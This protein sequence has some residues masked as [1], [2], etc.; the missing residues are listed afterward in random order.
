VCLPCSNSPSI[1]L[2]RPSS[3]ILFGTWSLSLFGFPG[4]S[5]V[6]TRCVVMCHVPL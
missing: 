4:G 1:V 6:I 3:W 5:C 2:A